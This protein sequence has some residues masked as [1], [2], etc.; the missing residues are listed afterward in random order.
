LF[1]SAAA[2]AVFCAAGCGFFLLTSLDSAWGALIGS[3]S[4]D[5][6]FLVAVIIAVAAFVAGSLFLLWSS[7]LLVSNQTTIEFYGNHW[8]HKP[9]NPYDLGAP[10]NIASVFG[11]MGLLAL[12]IP[13]LTPPPGNGIIFPLN[14]GRGMPLPMLIDERAA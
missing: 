12:L 2:A 4:S 5:T 10:R 6:W 3:Q 13:S 9:G 14:A 11:E 8:G 1:V 7:Y